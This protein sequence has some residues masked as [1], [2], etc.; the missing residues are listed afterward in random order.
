MRN[1]IA[2]VIVERPRQ[3]GHGARKGRASRDLE[4]ARHA[5]GMK[6]AAS[7]SGDRKMLNE[8]LAPLRRYFGRQ[9]GRPWNKVWSEVCTNLRVTSTVQQHV[10]DHIGDF[11]AYEGVSRRDGKVYVHWY[12]G[13]TRPLENSLF[14]FW[15]DPATGILRRNKR[16][17]TYRMKQKARRAEW[18]AELHKRM[19]ERDAWHQFH[20]LDD[21]AWWEVSLEQEPPKP[22]IVDVVLSAGLSALSP[23]RLYGRS[24][25]YAVG[26]RQLSKKEIKRL[27]LPRWS[28]A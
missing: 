5:V 27:K 3:G 8:N 20:L 12:W 16:Q 14:E 4:L 26:K 21:G 11:V 18:L 17:Q 23:G 22:P 28:R 25:V 19:V 13:G 9:I 10:R 15:V 24:G 6:R 2:K 1:D 7:E